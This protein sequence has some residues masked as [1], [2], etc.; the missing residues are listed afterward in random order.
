MSDMRG[1]WVGPAGIQCSS[2][3]HRGFLCSYSCLCREEQ[4]ASLRM[5]RE[6]LS[7]EVTFELSPE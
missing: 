4:A 6:G 2:Y 5:V 7:E 1:G 3:K